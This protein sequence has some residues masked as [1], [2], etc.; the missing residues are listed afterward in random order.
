MCCLAVSQIIGIYSTRFSYIRIVILAF[1]IIAILL[2]INELLSL[3]KNLNLS[4]DRSR[5]RQ[6]R[7]EK[8]IEILTRQIIKVDN[9][10]L[11]INRLSTAQL[12]QS[13]NP[14]PDNQSIDEDFTE[15]QL[16]IEIKENVESQRSNNPKTDL[17]TWDILIQALHFPNDCNDSFGYMA[18]RIARKTNAISELLQVSE[19]FLNLL[20]QDGIYLDDLTIEPPSVEAW[21]NFIKIDQNHNKRKLSCIGIDET[22]I[23]LRLRLKKD[24]I[25]RDTA[26]ILMRRFDQFLRDKLKTADDHHI[27]KIANTRSGKAF[28]IIGKISDSF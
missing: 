13:K 3:A 10:L 27:F 23:K 8:K 7:I 24:T 11:K 4:L 9:K 2:I 19:D 15:D 17:L 22:I 26:L 5:D 25:F 14:T 21:I 1:A 18:M 20:A 16:E 28:L 12:S 6:H